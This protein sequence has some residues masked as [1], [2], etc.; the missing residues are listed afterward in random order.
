MGKDGDPLEAFGCL[1][2]GAL[3]MLG[4]ALAR[5]AMAPW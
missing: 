1:L 4:L 2:A 5:A 3:L